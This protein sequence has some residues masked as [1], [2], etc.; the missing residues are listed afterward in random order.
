MIKAKRQTEKIAKQ[1][2]ATNGQIDRDKKNF[3]DWQ[4]Q[5]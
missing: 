3:L 5:M 4:I 2:K 1:T